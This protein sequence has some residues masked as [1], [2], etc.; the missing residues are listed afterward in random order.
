[1]DNIQ[2]KLDKAL[3]LFSKSVQQ[4]K[5]HSEKLIETK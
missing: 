5:F 1:M 4:E 2:H 3:V